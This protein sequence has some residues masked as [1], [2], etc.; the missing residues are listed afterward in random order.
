MSEIYPKNPNLITLQN[1]AGMQVII[2]DWGATIHSIKIPVAGKDQLRE[3]IIG[4]ANPEDYDRQYCY[5]GA[6]IGR[7]ANRIDHGQFFANGKEYH[8]GGG[9]DVVLHGG[10]IGFDKLRFTVLEQND[11]CATLQL[12]SPN[13]QEGFPG[14]FNLIVK[15]T[16]GEDCSLRMDYHATC[17]QECPA[18]ITNHSYLNLNGKHCKVLNHEAMFNAKSILLMDPRSIPTGVVYDVT[19]KPNDNFNFTSFKK[20]APSGSAEDFINDENMH[21]TGG[22]DHAYIINDYGDI[23]KPCATIRG[24]A[25]D[26]H[27]VQLEIY[28]NYPAFQFYSGNAINL[29]TPDIAIARDDNKEYGAH[30]GFALEPEFFPDA[31]HLK[32]FVETNPTVTPKRPLNRFIMYKFSVR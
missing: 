15:Y 7:Y 11:R 22:Y 27:Q 9:E 30:D 12:F 24:E 5:M 6:T 19:A 20:L 28:T 26:G 10:K 1:S 18:C 16:L 23:T 17:D 8:V 3:V 21:H 31:P 14:N 13:G 4:P 25:I 2:M 29:N 32:D